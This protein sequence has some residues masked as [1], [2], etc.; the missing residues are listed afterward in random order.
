MA[1]IV[2]A[3]W[4]ARI[5]VLFERAFTGLLEIRR[6]HLSPKKIIKRWVVVWLP[7]VYWSTGWIAADGASGLR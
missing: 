1:Q 4:T 7:T 5:L 2:K 3:A 6:S